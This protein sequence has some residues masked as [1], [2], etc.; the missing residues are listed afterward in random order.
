MVFL[1]YNF[2]YLVKNLI[3]KS[4]Y[5]YWNRIF[6]RIKWEFAYTWSKLDL[7]CPIILLYIYI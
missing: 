3:E 7:K 2:N 5:L 6:Y 4:N 1:F